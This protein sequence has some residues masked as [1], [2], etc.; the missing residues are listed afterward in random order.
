MQRL[1]IVACALIAPVICVGNATIIIVPK[2]FIYGCE[3]Y[4]DNNYEDCDLTYNCRIAKI[5]KQE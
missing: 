4:L 5:I 2:D 3:G 1:F